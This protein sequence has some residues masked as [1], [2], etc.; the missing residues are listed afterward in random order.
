MPSFAIPSSDFNRAISVTLAL[1]LEK[2]V[3]DPLTVIPLLTPVQVDVEVYVS[4]CVVFV[5]V[6]PSVQPKKR[7]RVDRQTVLCSLMYWHLS[8]TIRKPKAQGEA[9]E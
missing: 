2:D 3:H 1:S 5:L 4:V 8:R 7:M 6:V 9:L